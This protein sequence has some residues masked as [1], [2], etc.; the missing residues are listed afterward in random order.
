VC[1]HQEQHNLV[2]KRKEPIRTRELKE[3]MLAAGLP[4]IM[5]PGGP[6]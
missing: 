3:Q 5:H 2:R 4:V 1:R 6:G